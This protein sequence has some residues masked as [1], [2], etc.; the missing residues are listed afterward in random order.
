M[1]EHHQVMTPSVFP[2]P[3]SLRDGSIV[4]SRRSLYDT[5]NAQWR[6]FNQNKTRAVFI[7]DLPF[8]CQSEDLKGFIVAAL[9]GLA[10]G[11]EEVTVRYGQHGKTLQVA[12][13]L[14]RE[15]SM[16]TYAIEH[17]HGKRLD[18]RDLR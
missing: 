13:V 2:S 16:A 8:H 9:P 10:D 14:F 6:L 1:E 12:C 15:E 18:G 5:N 4:H 3:R 17:L 7:R 11:I